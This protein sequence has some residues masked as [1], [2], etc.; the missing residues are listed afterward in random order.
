[1]SKT[2]E[3]EEAFGVALCPRD[4]D[5]A[6]YVAYHARFQLEQRGYGEIARRELVPWTVTRSLSTPSNRDDALGLRWGFDTMHLALAR[7]EYQGR[8][9]KA[10]DEKIGLSS[11]LLPQPAC[12]LDYIPWMQE[13]VRGVQG[14]G[15]W[16]SS[17]GSRVLLTEAL[18]SPEG[19]WLSQE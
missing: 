17:E 4:E 15:R 9:V 12:V 8:I 2:E 16:M 14:E 11:V 6:V 19:G 18:V 7:S 1:L 13:M 5:M 3:P 10:L